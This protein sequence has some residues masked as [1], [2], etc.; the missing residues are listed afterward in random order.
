MIRIITFLL[1]TSA[2]PIFSQSVD[3][4]PQSF[5][6]SF[7]NLPQKPVLERKNR[8]YI[9]T[10]TAD[11]VYDI[12]AAQDHFEENVS[13]DGFKRLDTNGY[14][15]ITINLQAPLALVQ[16]IRKIETKTKDAKG[17]EK[18]EVSYRVIVKC[19]D[20]GSFKVFCS[21][22]PTFNKS[23]SLDNTFTDEGSYSNYEDAVKFGDQSIAVMKN[24]YFA[25][26]I[27]IIDARLNHDY[28]YV[29][30]QSTD[31]LW[32]LDSKKHPEFDNNIKA[33]TNVKSVF[34]KMKYNEDV[35][36]LKAELDPVISYFEGIEKTFAEDERK[37][38]KLRYGAYYNL[39]AIYYY[40]D[41]PDQSDIW[42]DKLIANKYDA[43]DGTS[44]KLRNESLR[45]L[46]EVNQVKTRHMDVEARTNGM[47]EEEKIDAANFDPNYLLKNNPKY[48]LIT[49]IL[50]S[51]DTI[52]GYA[53]GSEIA[54]LDRKIAI[55]IPDEK[56]NHNYMFKT[57][58]ADQ[59]SKL[60][61]QEY[62]FYSTV[63]FKEATRASSKPVFKFVREVLNGKTISLYQYFTGEVIVKKHSDTLGYSTNSVGWQMNTRT[64]FIELAASCPRLAARANSNEF[65][66]D[67]SSLRKFVEALDMCK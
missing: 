43:S 31:Y 50:S 23:Y 55:S 58:F 53:K 56:G 24:N 35:M 32:I 67:L 65:Q 13:I 15:E 44:M 22:D 21:S 28:G 40:L 46:F 5:N 12:K 19:R 10:V 41:M 39:A 30:E 61:I 17:I 27:N 36:P 9:I 14:F 64:K 25:R 33:L 11:N 2:M 57:F 8:T 45:T 49:L 20:L 18:T 38:R 4:D 42:C 63:S 60:I 7:V 52:S 16:E 48:S 26:T 1:L 47:V 51:N 3:L 59:V 54:N 66:N 37:Q 29:V 34:N 62:D 6:L